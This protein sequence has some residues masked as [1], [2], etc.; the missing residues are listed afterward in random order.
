MRKSS[1]TADEVWDPCCNTEESNWV[2][3]YG[4]D[5]LTYVSLKSRQVKLF[6]DLQ[7][8]GGGST[9]SRQSNTWIKQS[10]GLK[11]YFYIGNKT[12]MQLI[13]EKDFY[14]CI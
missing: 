6:T 4:C 7:G 10:S 3:K 2:W 11:I 5:V 13:N 8:I 9:L 12:I 14:Y 1:D